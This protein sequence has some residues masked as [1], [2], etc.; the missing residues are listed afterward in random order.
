MGGE[1]KKVRVRGMEVGEGTRRKAHG[2]R[3]PAPRCEEG[4]E[5]FYTECQERGRYLGRT[6]WKV[7]ELDVAKEVVARSVAE[8]AE[9]VAEP[10]VRL[11]EVIRE[12]GKK[13]RVGEITE[14]ER[15]VRG[16]RELVVPLGPKAEC[17]GLLRRLGKELVFKDADPRFIAG[18]GSTPTAVGVSR[19]S[20]AWRQSPGV[21]GGYQLRPRVGGY[22]GRGLG[23]YGRGRGV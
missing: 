6:E 14:E 15:E 4:A 8:E 7:A 13:R 12:G 23:G 9:V 18:G 21:S 10:K 11:P 22:R 17:G 2:D 5:E 1:G 19:R 3:V 16:V 20:E